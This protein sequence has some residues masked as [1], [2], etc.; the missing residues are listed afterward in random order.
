[1]ANFGE[2]AVVSLGQYFWSRKEKAM[3][4]KGS[5]RSREG[6]FKQGSV[7]NNIIW[8]RA[9]IDVKQEAV[10]TVAAMGYFARENF[11]SVSLL[12]KELEEREKVL[13][14][15]KQDQV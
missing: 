11:D 8:K 3:D 13:Q 12:N 14:R 1:M 9:S 15:S 7:P 4:K 6:T 5:K 10:K 2:D